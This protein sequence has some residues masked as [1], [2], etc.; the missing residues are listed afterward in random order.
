MMTLANGLHLANGV[1][2]V[3]ALLQ[4]GFRCFVYLDGQAPEA[5][6]IKELQP[7]ALLV[8]RLW[9]R[10]FTWNTPYALAQRVART[11][12]EHVIPWNEGNLTAETGDAAIP[13]A[14]LQDYWEQL[15]YYVRQ[16]APQKKLHFPAWSP[17]DGSVGPFW[18]GADVYD[19]HCYG[20]PQDMLAYLDR[21]LP[22]IP[23][24]KP[25]FVSEWNC[26]QPWDT[27]PPEWI[28]AFLD[29]LATRPQVIGATAFI[30]RWEGADPNHPN[31]DLQDTAALHILASWRTPGMTE[32]ERI[33]I[34]RIAD[35]FAGWA[36]LR[37]ARADLVAQR[38]GQYGIA[39]TLDKREAVE[40]QAAADGL[41]NLL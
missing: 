26:G 18:P 9:S 7:D 33:E 2:D 30:L 39:D 19:L 22:L 12:A 13:M 8:C 25:I 27:A 16:A 38:V 11:A 21:C 41:R 4:M 36:D 23:D 5:A 3:D 28:D 17:Y 31:L 14:V 15:T 32:Q 40:L 35:I 34:R 37:R 24:G 29:G 6:R 1:Q 10:D 20:E